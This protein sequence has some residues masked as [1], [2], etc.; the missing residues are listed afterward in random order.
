MRGT[1]ELLSAE[2]IASKKSFS[3]RSPAS[4]LRH[5]CTFL[6]QVENRTQEFL[7]HSAIRLTAK[8]IVAIR[9]C[10]KTLP[11]KVL[12]CLHGTR[13]AKANACNTSNQEQAFRNSVRPVNM[14]AWVGPLC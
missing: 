11:A 6:D 7:P 9:I 3:S 8:T 4:T 2:L 5:I 1:P 10:F 14:T 13:P 12:W